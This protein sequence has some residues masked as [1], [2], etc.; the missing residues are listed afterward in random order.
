MRR[1]LILWSV[2]LAV[3]IAAFAITIAVL[4]STMYSA[5]GFVGSYLDALARKDSTT[6]RE[7]PGVLA[8]EDSATDLLADAALGELTDVHEIQDYRDSQGIHTVTFGY[9]INGESAE[10][11]YRVRQ[12]GAFLGLFPTWTFDSTPL[13]TVAVT[14]LHDDRFRANGLELTNEAQSSESGGFSVFVPGLYSFDHESTFLTADTID[15]VITEP[16]SVTAVQVNVQAN[17]EFVKQVKTE[18]NDFLDKCAT[19]EVLQPTGCPFG[20]TFDNRVDTTPAWSITEYPAIEIVPGTSTGGWLVPRTEAAAHL[21]VE[22]RSL[23][24]GRRTPFDEDIPFDVAYTITIGPNDHL[25]IQA[26]N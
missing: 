5:G 25:S 11:D 16:G 3:L 10:S 23:F 7:L 15:A 13:G 12:T 26:M 17:Q 22:V 21:V 20:K 14:V 18:L 24:D 8:S 1:A 4:G 9:N 19:Q 2:A 6:A